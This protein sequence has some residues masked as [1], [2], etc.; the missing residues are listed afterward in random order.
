VRL[1]LS[2]VLL[3][4][5][6]F[7]AAN[8]AASAAAWLLGRSVIRRPGPSSAGL[9]LAVRLLPAVASTV[10]VGAVF[11]PA[12]WRFEPVESDESF[13]VVLAVIAA[14]GLLL[15]LRALGRAVR[16]GVAGRRLAAV[17][18]RAASLSDGVA[19]GSSIRVVDGLPGVSLF[20][21]WRPRILIGAEARGVLTAAELDLAI[22]HEVAHRRSKDNLKRFL[23]RC[24]PDLFSWTR[25][26]RE[27]EERWQ[28]AAECE[29]D[30]HAVKG[31]SYRAVLLASA[32]VKVARLGRAASASGVGPAAIASAFHVPTLLEMRV[33]RLVSGEAPPPAGAGRLVWSGAT[34]SVAISAGVWLLGFSDQLHSVTEAM[35]TY[36]P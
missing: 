20:G 29:A 19:V 31:D 21:I 30:A 32:L 10:F 18:R 8:A 26:A 22:S 9:L 25:V 2:S 16:A 11:L 13:G 4:L 7:T 6:W 34:L 27:L 15:M 35:V 24:A 1:I 12:H 17:A 28:A 23:I 3:G 14:T 33:R 5:A 36:L